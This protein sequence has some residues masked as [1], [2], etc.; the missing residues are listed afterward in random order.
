MPTQNW[1]RA[2]SAAWLK[3]PRSTKNC[4]PYFWPSQSS[5]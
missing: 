1:K 5:P 4:G 3:I 2:N